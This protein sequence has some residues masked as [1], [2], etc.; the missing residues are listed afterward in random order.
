MDEVQQ[1][2]TANCIELPR[3]VAAW[4]GAWIA[5]IGIIPAEALVS[6]YSSASTASSSSVLLQSLEFPVLVVG[7]ALIGHLAQFLFDDRRLRLVRILAAVLA[8]D[9]GFALVFRQLVG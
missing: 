5:I 6:M 4:L 9:V 2:P 3:T 1:D 8:F 7:G